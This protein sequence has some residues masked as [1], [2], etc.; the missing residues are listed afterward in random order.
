[1]NLNCTTR[2]KMKKIFL[3]CGLSALLLL[4]SMNAFAQAP[5]AFKY[6]AVARNS[7]GDVIA[8]QS[9]SFRLRIAEGSID[10]NTVYS[11]TQAA[12]TNKFGLVNLNIGN[13]TIV[14]GNFDSIKW[15]NGPYFIKIELDPKGGD[16]YTYMGA[17]QMESVPYALYAEHAKI[18]DNLPVF[19][20][21]AVL[22]GTNQAYLLITHK[23]A[24]LY[25]IQILQG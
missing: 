6:Q 22:T 17:S 4:L 20:I 19:P 14:T 3:S 5:Q 13:G 18:V 2:S 16:N 15:G 23:R 7:N 25:I 21:K 24:C 1:M 8:D 12:T 11:E 10:G 9:V